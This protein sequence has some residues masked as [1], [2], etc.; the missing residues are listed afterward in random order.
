MYES[1]GPHTAALYGREMSPTEAQGIIHQGAG[2][3][4]K[5]DRM[6]SGDKCPG[7]PGDKGEGDLAEYWSSLF[8]R[9]LKN[10]LYE[11]ASH[12]YNREEDA[13]KAAEDWKYRLHE[14]TRELLTYGM[15]ADFEF[16]ERAENAIPHF[17]KPT[18]V[19]HPDEPQL[20]TRHAL[21][22]LSLLNSLFENYP[23]TASSPLQSVF[24]NV[25]PHGVVTVL[26]FRER[27][28]SGEYRLGIGINTANPA[29][30]SVGFNF[31]PN[32]HVGPLC[33]VN[34]LGK[35][36]SLKPGFTPPTADSLCRDVMEAFLRDPK[37]RSFNPPKEP[38]LRWF[39][40]STQGE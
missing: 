23:D 32:G 38:N 36:A 26:R 35:V 39:R 6:L 16:L 13:T 31:D 14:R 8:N 30:E 22:R 19:H 34:P 4:E 20:E 10:V 1:K 27:P 21:R 17:S 5:I 7:L 11:I 18:V 2:L 9:D 40:E 24:V 37:A 29:W 3:A 33:C 15:M 25:E 12:H 28:L